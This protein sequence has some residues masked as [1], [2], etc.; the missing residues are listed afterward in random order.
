MSPVFRC[1]MQHDLYAMES[2]QVQSYGESQC[3]DLAGQEKT[4]NLALMLV[5]TSII[6]S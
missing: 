5:F 6:S 4:R 2:L 1:V 3:E